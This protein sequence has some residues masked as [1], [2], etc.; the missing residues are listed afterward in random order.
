MAIASAPRFAPK[1][2][3]FYGYFFSILR[4][5]GMGFTGVFVGYYEL[6]WVNMGYY[7]SKVYALIR[8]V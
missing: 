6:K 1:Y 2:L 8:I 5:G 3:S 4:G 7:D